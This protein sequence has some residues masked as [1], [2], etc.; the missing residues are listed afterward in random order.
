MSQ[1]RKKIVCNAKPKE[2]T[3]RKIVVENGTQIGV[4]KIVLHDE[5]DLHKWPVN[6]SLHNSAK[7]IDCIDRA[8][9][10]KN[11]NTQN[12]ADTDGSNDQLQEICIEH[13]LF[14]NMCF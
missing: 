7:Q 14:I 8:A 4:Y 9:D 12:K 3:R 2:K 6:S 5:R 1:S 11:K 13:R 10:F